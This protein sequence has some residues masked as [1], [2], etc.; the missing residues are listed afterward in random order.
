MSARRQPSPQ[1][2]PPDHYATLGLPATAT[3]A[4]IKRAYRD[5]A[6][7][8]HPDVSTA[9]PADAAARF[10]AIAQAYEILSDPARRAE[11]DRLV[12]EHHAARVS[13]PVDTRA[14]YTWTNIAAQG[15]AEAEAANRASELDELYDTFFGSPPHAADQGR[16]SRSRKS[17][18]PER[19]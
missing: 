18:G 14:H 15:A 7:S 16:G 8:H 2:P 12:R 10:A 6:K 3:P 11:H 13:S 4:Q 5:L 19:A 17:P 9:P 1:S